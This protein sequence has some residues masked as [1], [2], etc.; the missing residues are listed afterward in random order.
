M[1]KY[2]D[3]VT[4]H[5]YFAPPG[6]PDQPENFVPEVGCL[7]AMMAKYGQQDK[8]L[9][10]TEGS[11]G[12]A[13]DLPDTNQ[14]AAFVARSYLLLWSEGVA[15]FYWYRLDSARFGILRNQRNTINEAGVAYEQV[16]KWMVGATMT[17]PCS[18]QANVWTC[19][20]TLSDGTVAQAVWSDTPQHYTA[21]RYF[22]RYRTLWRATVEIPSGRQVPIGPKPKLLE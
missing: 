13:R 18:E 15:R 7:R 14:Q 19:Y 12:S 1:G 16:A 22:T 4:F 8:P 3:V 11:W 9:W 2:I 10:S 17:R 20:L 6:G 21:P 5:S